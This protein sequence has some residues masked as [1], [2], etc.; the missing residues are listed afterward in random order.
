MSTSPTP[1]SY[2][3]RIKRALLLEVEV[4]TFD[5][6]KYFLSKNLDDDFLGDLSRGF[7]PEINLTLL[8]IDGVKNPV[9]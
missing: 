2:P 1:L 9:R 3:K 5:E 4:H 8:T 6:E 7:F